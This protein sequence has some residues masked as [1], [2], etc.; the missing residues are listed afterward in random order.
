MKTQIAELME[1]VG[2]EAVIDGENVKVL[3]E[4]GRDERG[5][6]TKILTF[7]SFADTYNSVVFRGK[8][9]KVIDAFIDEFGVA[10]ITIGA[11]KDV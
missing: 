3:A 5:F 6:D 7:I 2:E 4:F 11:S 9:Y 8:T 1:S 10:R